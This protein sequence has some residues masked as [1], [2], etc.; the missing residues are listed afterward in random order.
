MR[1]GR[2]LLVLVA[3][4]SCALWAVPVGAGAHPLG[5]FTINQYSGIEVAT[6][7]VVVHYAVDMAEIP[8]I[9]ELGI[10]S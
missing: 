8:T 5:N 4:A 2:R 3:L 6:D 1:R 7:K 9:Q 10:R